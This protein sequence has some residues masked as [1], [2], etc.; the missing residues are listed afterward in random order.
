MTTYLTTLKQI[1]KCRNIDYAVINHVVRYVILAKLTFLA[2]KENVVLNA[3]SKIP[4]TCQRLQ[5]C[6]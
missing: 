5:T 4:W 2:A 6:I 1:H 3:N